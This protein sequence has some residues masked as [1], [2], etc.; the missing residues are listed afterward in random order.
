[1]VEFGWGGVREP[2][3]KIGKSEEYVSHRLQLLKLPNTIKEQISLNQLNVS[4]A[5]ELVGVP[6]ASRSELMGEIINNML[7]VKQIREVK[8]MILSKDNDDNNDSYEGKTYKSGGILKKT[9]LSLKITLAR[10]DILIEEVHA[11]VEPEER[12]Q[13]I[14]FLMQTR[15][16]IHSI[17]DDTIRFKNVTEKLAV[18]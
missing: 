1:M 4:Q 8:S 11:T 7:T 12:A 17:I 13:I 6:S 2:A 18:K 5:I 9:T 16:K 15:L 3:K 14:G 10:I